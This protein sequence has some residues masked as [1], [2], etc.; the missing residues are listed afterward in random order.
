[1]NRIL[2]FLMIACALSAQ[3]SS[4]W[5][6]EPIRWVQTNLREVDSGSGPVRLVEEAARMKA[7]VLHVNMGG[8]VATYPTREPYHIVSRS[9]PPGRAVR[10]TVEAKNISLN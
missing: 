4:W 1:M 8:I 6:R 10:S 9:L 3:D 7:N 2:L 5:M